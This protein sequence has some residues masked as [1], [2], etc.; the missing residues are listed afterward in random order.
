M[1]AP[2]QRLEADA[3]RVDGVWRM[4]IR[5]RVRVGADGTPAPQVEA[6]STHRIGR[7]EV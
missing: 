1:T 6:L 2:D 4:L 3:T 7:H 5:V